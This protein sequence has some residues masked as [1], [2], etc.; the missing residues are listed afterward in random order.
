MNLVSLDQLAEEC[1]ILAS[2]VLVLCLVGIRLLQV[3]CRTVGSGEV[4]LNNDHD[5]I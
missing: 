1:G 4:Q 2:L 3:N 5:K